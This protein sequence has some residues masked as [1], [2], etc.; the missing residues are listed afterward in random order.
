[1]SH[2]TEVLEFMESAQVDE[3]VGKAWNKTLQAVNRILEAHT[4]FGF[5]AINARLNPSLNDILHSLA[6]IDFA[7]TIFL[8]SDV[9]GH[10]EKRLALNSKQCVLH[11]R[12][13]SAALECKDQREY[14]AAISVLISQPQI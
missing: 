13:L 1:M 6:I 3:L 7:L 8:D 5:T 14:D 12:R 10:D 11:L 2:H 9:L 4:A